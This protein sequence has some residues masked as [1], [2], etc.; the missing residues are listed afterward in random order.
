LSLVEDTNEL[1][2]AIEQYGDTPLAR[3]EAL[4]ELMSS[5]GDTIV[6]ASQKAKFKEWLL[7]LYKYISE[8]FKSLMKLSPKEVE[9]ITLDKFLEGMLA[10][11]LSGKELTTS[12][13]KGETKFSKESQ[14]DSIRKFIEI[15]RKKGLTDDEIRAGIIKVAEQIGL[16]KSKINGLFKKEPKTEIVTYKDLTRNEKRQIINSK[17]DELVKELKIEKIC[18][19]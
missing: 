12:K 8:N 7:S 2:K 13:I 3:E 10:D 16:D 15:Q 9:N 1:K 5:K 6:N 17:F 14:E 18:P 19:T 4:M 11:I